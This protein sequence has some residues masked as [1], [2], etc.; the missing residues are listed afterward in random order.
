MDKEIL[1]TILSYV[2]TGVVL[3]LLGY[4]IFKFRTF[5]E[6]KIDAINNEDFRRGLS[7]A[8]EELE[9]AVELAVTDVA[10]TFVKALKA[11]GKFG[12][13]EAQEAVKLATA[14]TKEIVSDMGLAMFEIAKINIDSSI[15]SLIETN[16]VLNK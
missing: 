13:K 10:E 1:D 6:A 2:I 5:I 16:V 4:A 3:P 15:K 7:E 8:N 12:K 11:E 14:K 9:R